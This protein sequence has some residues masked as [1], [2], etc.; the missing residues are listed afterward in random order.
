MLVQ[1]GLFNGLEIM[2]EIIS[3]LL[4]EL[5]GGL[6]MSTLQAETVGESN[7]MLHNL[8]I[9][10]EGLF[11]DLETI[12]RMVTRPSSNIH[13]LLI[14][15]EDLSNDLE[16][17]SKR[18]RGAKSSVHKLFGGDSTGNLLKPSVG[19]EGLFPAMVIHWLMDK[20]FAEA[21]TLFNSLESISKMV[22]KSKNN[23]FKLLNNFVQ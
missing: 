10:E 1:E 7:N 21:E 17:V 6:R 14:E 9:E 22:R 2:F 19:E 3:A 5:F 15:R 13:K 4:H 18:G 8:C 23:L 20:L 16:M 12:S 11:N